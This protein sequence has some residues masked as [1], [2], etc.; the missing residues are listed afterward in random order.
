MEYKPQW[1]TS[2]SWEESGVIELDPSLAAVSQSWPLPVREAL[3]VAQRFGLP[4]E[5][6]K[7]YP[8][9]V[10]A[11]FEEF[12]EDSGARYWRLGQIGAQSSPAYVEL[13]Y[14]LDSEGRVLVLDDSLP[15]P[16]FVNSSLIAFLDALAA[17]DYRCEHVDDFDHLEPEDDDD[18]DDPAEAA[19]VAF[20]LEIR[21]RLRALDPPAFEMDTWWD[22]VY[23]EVALD[24]I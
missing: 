24:A 18:E 17:Y 3:R 23:E 15:E 12:S 11:P 16:R 2:D 21:D 7:F 22:R 1:L 14:V 8:S 19:R 6:A 9:T 13:Q 5:A 10:G 20:G 4:Q